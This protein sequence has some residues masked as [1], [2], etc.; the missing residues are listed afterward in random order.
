MKRNQLALILVLLAALGGVALLLRSRDSA[1]W[2]S[3]AAGS[4]EKIL[5]FPLNDVSRVT[6][7][8]S[9]TELNLVKQEGTWRVAERADYPADFGKVAGLLR[10]LWE[11]RATQDVKA[12][13]SQ[14][15]RLELLEPGSTSDSGT[16]IELT[17]GSAKP[18]GSLLLGK[19]QNQMSNRSFGDVSISVGRYVMSPA[20]A[21]RV[22][23]VA[24][25][26]DEVQPKPDLWISR[27][28]LKVE[29]PKSIALAGA[30]PG[31]NWK[32]SRQTVTGP[33]TLL[34]AKPGEEPDSTKFNTVTSY[35][36]NL[37]FADV[38]KADALPAETGLDK[39]S[40]LTIETFD[41]F[42]YLLRI[43][44][45]MGTNYPVLVSVKASLPNERKP[46][47]DEKPADKARLDQ[48]F[49]EKQ[50][51]LNEKLTKEEKLAGRP[52]LVAKGT[53]EHFLKERSALL[54][55]EP[56]PAPTAG[57]STKPR[58]TPS[59]RPK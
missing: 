40:T 38:L 58:P 41:G 52:Y 47:A 44:K 15:G 19:K 9:G 5:S 46:G 10:K 20:H 48:Q 29:N 27:D 17:D 55:S 21:E 45:L 16:L 35:L 34:E 6:I 8:T 33:W 39:P 18:L 14:L 32:V 7:K 50:K 53:V 57:P 26:F 30:A 49:Q 42:D 43:G 4:S 51:Q 3:S 36:A 25:T 59:K 22:Y 23:L 37:G 31:M 13:P 12:G 56:P 54:K 11:L 28:F 2:S 24:E 1:S